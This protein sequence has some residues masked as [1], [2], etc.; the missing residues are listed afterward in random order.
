[1]TFTPANVEREAL[2]RSSVYPYDYPGGAAVARLA[3]RPAYTFKLTLGPLARTSLD[4]LSAI[5]KQL[6]GG[7][8]FLWDGGPFG[9]VNNLH[10]VGLGD[11]A[12]R[13]FYLPNRQINAS[14]FSAG[15]RSPTGTSSTWATGTYSLNAVPGIVTYSAA[16][17]INHDALAQWACDYLVF[18]DEDGIAIR[19]NNNNA[20]FVELRLTESLYT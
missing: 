7:D 19:T 3:T 9:A 11:G 18:F 4:S 5:H 6:Q 2:G 12:T 15:T 16:P 14:S 10:L 8:A 13:T 20:Y 17:L 1:M